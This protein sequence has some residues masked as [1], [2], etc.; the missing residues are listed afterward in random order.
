MPCWTPESS[1]QWRMSVES[2]IVEDGSPG[3][4]SD[5]DRVIGDGVIGESGEKKVDEERQSRQDE[6]EKTNPF[7]ARL[8]QE[9]FTFTLHLTCFTTLD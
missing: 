9:H 6:T 2:R 3:E 7:H 8:Q 5:R 4:E 1:V